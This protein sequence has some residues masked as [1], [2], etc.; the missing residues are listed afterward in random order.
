MSEQILKGTIA[1]LS[2]H[3]MSGLWTLHF[4]E[5]GSVHI[6]S[7]YGVRTLSACFGA[8]EGSGDLLEK[9]VGKEIFYSTDAFGVLEAF[10][11]VEEADGDLLEAYE[12]SLGG[13]EDGKT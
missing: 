4:E 1:G 10:T 9:I 6:G 7:G 11:P 5:G 3:P 2:G 13:N 8:S 12:K